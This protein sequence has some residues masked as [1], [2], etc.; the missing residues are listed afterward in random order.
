MGLAPAAV[1]LEGLE[2]QRRKVQA[3]KDKLRE[4]RRPYPAIFEELGP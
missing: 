2:E 4:R 3:L 1:A